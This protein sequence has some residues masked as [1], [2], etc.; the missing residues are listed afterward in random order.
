M[1]GCEIWA[2]EHMEPCERLQLKFLKML[3]NVKNSTP[4]CMV[5]GELGMFPCYI[6]A[7]C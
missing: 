6:E 5:Y 7:K 4:S 2:G 1:Y 3:L